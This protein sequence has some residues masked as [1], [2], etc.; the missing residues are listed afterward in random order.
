MSESFAGCQKHPTKEESGE[1][2]SFYEFAGI[3]I[4][5]TLMS[6]CLI[7]AGNIGRE[8]ITEINDDLL[9]L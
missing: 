8:Q 7:S 2:P 9:P 4:S 6:S 3:H 1:P 5:A